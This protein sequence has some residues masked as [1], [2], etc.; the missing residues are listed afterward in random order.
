M[1]GFSIKSSAK[2]QLREAWMFWAIFSLR[3]LKIF[4]VKPW[5]HLLPNEIKA[6]GVGRQ[7]PT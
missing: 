6:W 5:D 1:N 3:S 2:D 4:Q 7:V